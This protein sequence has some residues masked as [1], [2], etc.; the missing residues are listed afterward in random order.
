L[1]PTTPAGISLLLSCES[2]CYQLVFSLVATSLTKLGRYNGYA[3]VDKKLLF[4][5]LLLQICGRRLRWRVFCEADR[6]RK[7]YFWKVVEEGVMYL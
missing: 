1:R 4:K 5:K 2:H 6:R 7:G 3:V